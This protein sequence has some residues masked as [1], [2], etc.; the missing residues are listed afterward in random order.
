MFESLPWPFA[1]AANA[2]KPLQPSFSEHHSLPLLL[3]MTS[4]CHW[5]GELQVFS[6]CMWSQEFS[7]HHSHDRKL[8]G[9]NTSSCG[10]L[11]ED[12]SGRRRV[13]VMNK[14]RVVVLCC[15]TVQEQKTLLL[16]FSKA[17]CRVWDRSLASHRS[18]WGAVQVPDSTAGCREIIL[19]NWNVSISGG[20]WEPDGWAVVKNSSVPADPP[21]G[22]G[23][24]VGDFIWF[25]STPM[26]PWLKQDHGSTGHHSYLTSHNQ[27][28]VQL[29]MVCIS[30]VRGLHLFFH[31]V[32][33]STMS[34]KLSGNQTSLS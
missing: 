28:H 30:W 26:I 10:G 2:V 29:T 21:L 11:A 24:K 7:S 8:K 20:L 17:P 22:Q 13:K 1:L 5:A 16:S 23:G 27:H 18:G 19:G 34:A 33:C 4:I 25:F 3:S 32:L 6:S 9:S 14:T 15:S 31:A 12:I